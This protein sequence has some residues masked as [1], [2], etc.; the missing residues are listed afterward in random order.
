VK[1]KPAHF[2]RGIQ[3]DDLRFYYFLFS[4]HYF[5]NRMPVNSTVASTAEA[6]R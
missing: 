6:L 1:S 2:E 3:S 5:P 4:I